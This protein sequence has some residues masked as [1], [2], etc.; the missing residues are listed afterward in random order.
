LH[1]PVSPA[2]LRS[3]VS[4]FADLHRNARALAAEVAERRRIEDQL[5]AL[6]G[7]LERRVEERTNALRENQW[8]LRQAADTA[9]LTYIHVD[10]EKGVARLAENFGVVMGYT[11]APSQEV[12]ISG[13]IQVLLAHIVAEDRP[14]IE[15]ALQE[16]A[17]GK[18][19]PRI[20][21]RI[22]AEDLGERWIESACFHEYSYDGKPLKSFLT[23]IDITQRKAAEEKLRDSEERFR[24]LADSMPHMV[25]TAH[26][27]GLVNYCNARWFE[28]TGFGPE[29][30]GRSP[31]W[32]SLLH[33]ADLKRCTEAW[34][35]S[36]QSGEPHRIEYRL[37]DRHTNRYCWYLGRALPL[38]DRED[39]VIQWIGTCTDID[40]QKRSEEDLRRANQIL[41]QFAFSASHDLQ[42]PLRN[43]A[44]FTQLFAKQYGA[45][46]NEE[47]ESFLRIITEGAQRM[48][49]LISDLLAY[50]K[51]A[52]FDDNPV[53]IVDA[54]AIFQRVLKNLDR[55]VTESSATVTHDTLPPV[56]IR[57]VHLEQ[58]L[59][60]LVGNALK[61]RKDDQAPQVHISS[62]QRDREVCF[63][64]RDN[65]IGIAPEYQ[66][67]VFGIFKR[68]HANGTKYSGTG[69][70]LAI[71]QQIVTQ[72][73]GRIWV[74]SEIGRGAT[75]YFTVPAGRLN[76]AR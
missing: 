23:H 15:A 6:N 9:R 2:I 27:D 32:G 64:V 65:G 34:A 55:A 62:I 74:E 11:F 24:Q 69:I 73:G 17:S 1:K 50:T 51:I 68:L 54:E 33:P 4:V 7:S 45:G 44:I 46:L 60:N 48:G 13:L 12:N 43:V 39:R 47:A 67:E 30:Y 61:Y 57:E 36:V 26:R 42:E 52:H 75:F 35:N 72:H 49:R 59:Q 8:Q 41:E 40:E 37:W 22:I 58:L 5:H 28:F 21:Y 63:A 56:S 38:R 16:F 14:R 29:K 25:W 31:D 66:M 76:E 71:C 19:V 3:K 10:F 70:G 18:P 53:I 20:D